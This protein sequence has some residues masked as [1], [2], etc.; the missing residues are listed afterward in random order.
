MDSNQKISSPRVSVLLLT[1]NRAHFL[2]KAIASVLSQTFNDFELII[3][4]DGSTDNTPDIINELR[5]DRIRYIRHDK[6]AGLFARRAESLSYTKGDYIAVLDSDDIW[7]DNTKLQKQVSFLDDNPAYVLVGTGTTI[8]DE[9]DR[10][11]NKSNFKTTDEEIRKVILKKNQFTHSSI[12]M[13]STAIKQTIGYQPILAE[14]LEL[15]LQLG[16]FGKL[17][18]LPEFMT[19]HREHDQSEND[20]GIKMCS[21]VHQIIQKHQNYPGFWSAFIKSHLRLLYCRFKSFL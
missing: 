7:S 14:D 9:L 21:A 4:D 11:K 17:A 18:N 20:H 6:N 13:R 5:D 8:I 2:P 10:I 16:N 3:I 19:S 12:L 15:F 1:Y